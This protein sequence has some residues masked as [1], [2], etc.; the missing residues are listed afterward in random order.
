VGIG[1]LH[2]TL[3]WRADVWFYGRMC[4]MYSI[5][6]T[7]YKMNVNS[8]DGQHLFYDM[9]VKVVCLMNVY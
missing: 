2:K 7:K 6:K 4:K 1:K 8:E 3:D 9:C 5:N